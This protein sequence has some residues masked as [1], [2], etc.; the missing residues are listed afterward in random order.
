MVRVSQM[1]RNDDSKM[2][3]GPE[4]A[5]PSHPRKEVLGVWHSRKQV[6]TWAV[7]LAENC[8]RDS[9][10]ERPLREGMREAAA[11]TGLSRRKSTVMLRAT[12]GWRTFTTTSR[13]FPLSC[14]TALCT[15]KHKW[16]VTVEPDCK[17]CGH[18][19]QAAHFL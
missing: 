13:G 17:G 5:P 16:E 8:A 10:R 4:R 2:R 19:R 12:P 15:C 7:M 11:A 9:L 3:K 18:L 6:C 1:G 14:I